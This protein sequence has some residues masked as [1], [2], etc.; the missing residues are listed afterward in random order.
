MIKRRGQNSND[1]SKI[2]SATVSLPSPE[3]EAGQL[4]ED[5]REQESE[6]LTASPQTHMG[7]GHH[8]DLSMLINK[9]ELW[10]I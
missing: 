5:C 9:Q 10:G 8:S 7:K 6:P 3:Q 2:I 4:S 1:R